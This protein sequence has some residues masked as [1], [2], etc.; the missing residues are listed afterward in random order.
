MANGKYNI[1]SGAEMCPV[2]EDESEKFSMQS[3]RCL[4]S[5][6]HKSLQRA[7]G[8]VLRAC[9]IDFVYLSCVTKLF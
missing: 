7:A 1:H 5:W 4:V 9:L 3:Q 6:K 8:T 2:G